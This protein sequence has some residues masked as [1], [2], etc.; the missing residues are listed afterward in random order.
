MGTYAANLASVAL[1]ERETAS[2]Y[3]DPAEFFASTYF[4]EAMV[5]I[6]T[7]VW[8]ALTGRPGDR[9]LQLR[10]PFGGGKTHSL[11][12]LYHLAKHRDAAGDVPELADL[13]DPGPVRTAVLSGEYLDPQ[14]RRKVEGRK[15]GTLWGELAFQLGG[16]DAYDGLLVDGKEGTP[17]GGEKLGQLLEGDPALILIDEALIYIAKGKAIEEGDSNLGRL[18]LLF[19]QNLSEAVNQSRNAALVYSLQASVGE[20]VEDEASL[21]SLEHMAARID[22]RREPVTGDEVLR[23]VQRRLFEDLGAEG[24]R[25]E[26]ADRYAAIQQAELE[27]TAD[28]DGERREAKEAAET[29][30]DRILLSYPFHPELIDIMYLRWGSLPSYQRTRGALQFLATVIHALWGRDDGAVSSLIGPGEVDLDDE[31]TRSTF[32]EQVSEERQY[33]A[34]VQADFIAADAGS[35]HIDERIGRD[36]PALARLRVGTRVATAI[37]LM[38]FG[39]RQGEDRGALEREVVE[40]TLIP[41][42]DGNLIR[43]A[44]KELRSEALLYLHHTGRRYRFEPRPNLNKLIIAER[45]KLEHDEV[46]DLVRGALERDLKAGA[47]SGEVVVWPTEPEQINDGVQ[48]FRVAYLDPDWDEAKFPLESF[49]TANQRRF[50]NAVAL[51][52]PDAGAFDRARTAGRTVLAIDRLTADKSRH[53]FSDEQTEELQERRSGADAELRAAISDL[54]EKVVL[55]RNVSGGDVDLEDIDLSTVL[56]VGR[57]LHERVRAG[58]SN[59]VFDTIKGSKVRVIANLADREACSCEELAESMYIYLEM[60][61]VWAPAVLEQGVAEGVAGGLFGYCASVEITD[62]TASVKDPQLIRFKQPISADEVDLGPGAALLSPEAVGRLHP[63]VAPTNGAPEVEPG[64][65]DEEGAAQPKPGD[66]R[67]TVLIEIN[68][69]DDDLHTL[70]RALSNL[71]D[72]T[73][74]MRIRLSVKADSEEAIDR[75]KFQNLVREPLE[76]DEDVDFKESWS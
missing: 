25:A 39:A 37:M 43:A 72:L 41:D 29:L 65:G 42:L 74:Q 35:K 30:K 14:R 66:G 49:I 60:P 69:T 52:V 11:L 3:S 27:A 32:F 59:H 70:Q 15:I 46:T 16:A 33:R 6:L 57:G 38:S 9:V 53:Q 23:V 1:A 7:D 36:S 31:A 48:A 26:V 56:G 64:T 18:A 73:A 2:V 21:R 55:P 51:A 12:A 17:P 62:G 19:L 44:L 76:E 54:Y 63:E 4:T 47:H 71:R 58:L 22:A 45:D 20:A 28:N 10:T 13:P 8:D 75:V 50:K 40:A 68:A 5:G 67:Q 34:V 24:V 61:R